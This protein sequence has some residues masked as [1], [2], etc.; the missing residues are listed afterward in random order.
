MLNFLL[1]IRIGEL[2]RPS[3]LK[4]DDSVPFSLGISA[5]FIERIYDIACLILLFLIFVFN[6]KS[7]M[8][9]SIIW[10]ETVVSSEM[11]SALF[12]SMILFVFIF[13]ILILLCSFNPIKN[14][15]SSFWGSIR[16]GTFF[17]PIAKN[18]KWKIVEDIL[19]SILNFF[20]RVIAAFSIILNFKKGFIVFLHTL[21]VWGLA[22]VAQYTFFLGCPGV[23]LNFFESTAFMTIICFFIA[24]PS[25]PG[26]WGVW[27]AGGLFAMA[28]FEISVKD[29][30]G[31]IVVYHVIQIFF[32]VFLGCIS[33]YIFFREK[34]HSLKDYK[35][36]LSKLTRS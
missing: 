30:I 26:Y 29:A 6:L 5:V 21:I 27:E 9:Q 28:L 7:D 33:L 12:R 23:S 22:S 34:T 11:L 36:V 17:F 2:V 31:P 19:D 14:T 20:E 10:G 16:G 25:V 24:I 8:G 15:I 13:G 4:V 3:V 32:T 18:S 1:P 35:S